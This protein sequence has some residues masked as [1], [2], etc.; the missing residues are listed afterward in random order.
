VTTDQ[1]LIRRPLG[2]LSADAMK[3]IDARLKFSLGLP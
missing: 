2:M 1:A 3:Q